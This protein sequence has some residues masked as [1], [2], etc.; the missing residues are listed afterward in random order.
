MA[1]LQK[2]FGMVGLLAFVLHSVAVEVYLG[3]TPG[4]SERLRR[5]SKERRVEPGLEKD[6]DDDAQAEER[7]R[8][9]GAD[10]SKTDVVLT[11][12]T[13]AET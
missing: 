12:E 10:I 11:R 3:L 6:E 8:G 7:R 2:G 13:S 5:V 4:E 9:E 1:G